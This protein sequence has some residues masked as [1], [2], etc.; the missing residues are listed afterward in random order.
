[1]AFQM[2]GEHVAP[3]KKSG[4]DTLL[5]QCRG[6]TGRTTSRTRSY[7]CHLNEERRSRMFFSMSA[8]FACV[9]ILKRMSSVIRLFSSGGVDSRQSSNWDYQL[10]RD[11]CSPT[12]F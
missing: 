9:P 3:N 8:D 12:L 2:N 5:V 10:M 6:P 1:M 11:N 4:H 7:L